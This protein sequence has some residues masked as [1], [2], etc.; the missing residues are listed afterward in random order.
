MMTAYARLHTQICYI[1]KI[2]MAKLLNY[3]KNI[4]VNNTFANEAEIIINMLALRTSAI[5][6]LQNMNIINLLKC[7]KKLQIYTI[8]Y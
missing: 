3:S 7:W 5:S 4:L 6:E 1:M 8:I 2:Q